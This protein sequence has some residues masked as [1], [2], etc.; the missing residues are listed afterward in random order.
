MQYSIL[1]M[2]REYWELLIIS[3]TT[4]NPYPFVP[5]D[6]IFYV[7]QFTWLKSYEPP[8]PVFKGIQ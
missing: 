6:N 4:N 8:P 5:M 1:K 3:A 2:K 7:D